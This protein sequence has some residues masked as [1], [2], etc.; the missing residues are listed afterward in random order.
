MSLF[1]AKSFLSYSLRKLTSQIY[2]KFYFALQN[3][4]IIDQNICVSK[5]LWQ[6][7][8]TIIN[9]NLLMEGYKTLFLVYQ[10]IDNIFR[11]KKTRKIA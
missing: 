8:F 10:L 4:V 3:Y 7:K 1:V 5:N 11:I 2:G 6:R 9:Q